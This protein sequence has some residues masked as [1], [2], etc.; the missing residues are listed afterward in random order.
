MLTLLLLAS[1]LAVPQQ[2][3]AVYSKVLATQSHAQIKEAHEKLYQSPPPVTTGAEVLKINYP[4]P[5]SPSG[6]RRLSGALFLPTDT[7]PRGIVLFC[8]GTVVVDKEVPSRLPETATIAALPFLAQGFAV[9]MPDYVGQGDSPGRHPYPLGK[10]NAWSGID[11]IPYARSIAAARGHDPGQNV[12]ITGY[13]EGGAVAM[14]AGRHAEENPGL[15]DLKATAPLSGPYDL[16]GTTTK[17]LLSDQSNP[18][19]RAVRVFLAAYLGY[20]AEQWSPGV[21]LE[22]LFV[23]NF[24]SYVTTVFENPQSD[25][26]ITQ[27]L[28]NKFIQIRPT[29]RSIRSIVQPDAARALQNRDRRHPLV[30][31][32]IENDAYDWTP[33]HPFKMI[34]LENDFVVVPQ[35]T[36]VALQRMMDRGADPKTV[37]A[38]IIPGDYN[39]ISGAPLCHKK[40]AD[41]FASL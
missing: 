3:T 25:D 30:R 16:S 9:A 12:Y 14:W 20:S 15:L 7:T 6:Y 2:D 36:T 11:L 32:L 18:I 23:P 27:R 1:S 13:S 4:S 22:D 17:S 33:R 34:A 21:K 41:F 28:L 26:E 29:S 5:N 31:T 8:H 19:W 39:H 24:A 37:T 38:E 10:I 35:N 40:A